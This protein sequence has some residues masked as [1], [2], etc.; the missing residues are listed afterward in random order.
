MRQPPP[1]ISTSQTECI[2]N[3]HQ[4]NWLRLPEIAFAIYCLM[5]FDVKF[6]VSVRLKQLPVHQSFCLQ[7]SVHPLKSNA[8]VV[9]DLENVGTSLPSL[10]TDSRLP[11][12][13]K[14]FICYD[15][16]KDVRTLKNSPREASVDVRTILQSN[17]QAALGSPETITNQGG[18]LSQTLNVARAKL[19][20]Q[21]RTK[22]KQ[23]IKTSKCDIRLLMNALPVFR[24]CLLSKI[25]VLV[26]WFNTK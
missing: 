21:D 19:D 16:P 6:S 15:F 3:R 20:H 2:H 5:M 8:W 26:E 11:M 9:S 10:N 17:S 22:G 23:N 12:L 4:T 25:C 7:F 14:S 1:I 24:A 18:P 13:S